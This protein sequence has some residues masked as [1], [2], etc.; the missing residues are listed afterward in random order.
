MFDHLPNEQ[1][2]K[3]CQFDQMYD[4]IQIL[5]N[6]VKHANKYMNAGAHYYG[7][8]AGTSQLSRKKVAAKSQVK[9]RESKVHVP[10][11]PPYITD[12]RSYI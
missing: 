1:N 5:S 11:K 3:Q 7:K 4:I 8:V 12:E 6:T 9:K 10:L 2:I